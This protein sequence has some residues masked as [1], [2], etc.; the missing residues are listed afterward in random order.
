MYEF[1][2]SSLNGWSDR[3]YQSIFGHITLFPFG[4][5]IKSWESKLPQAEFAHNHALNRSS[6]FSLFQVIYGMV[7]C[8][9]LTL[10]LCRIIQVI[11]VLQLISLTPLT[12]FTHK[13]FLI[14]RLR[15]SI[16]SLK[17]KVIAGVLCL[18]LAIVFGHS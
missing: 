8:G 18:K 7:P 4:D 10:L 15:P 13:S 9:P 1:S 12:R 3:S 14:Y 16:I 11:M 17:L 5:L 6:G 2:L